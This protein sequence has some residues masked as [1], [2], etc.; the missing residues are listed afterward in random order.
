[1]PNFRF[2]CF[3]AKYFHSTVHIKKTYEKYFLDVFN[4]A[5]KEAVQACRNR[6]N[7]VIRFKTPEELKSVMDFSLSSLGSDHQ[8]LLRLC[9]GT[10]ENSVLTGERF[11]L[12]TIQVPTCFC[13][14]F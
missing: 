5:M 10:L 4:M 8:E 14:F 1:M 13:L 12:N 11:L 9:H 2:G 6:E 3:L 7:P